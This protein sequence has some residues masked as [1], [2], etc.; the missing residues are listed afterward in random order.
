MPATAYLATFIVSAIAH[1]F[2]V[3][4]NGYSSSTVENGTT[5]PIPWA[6][7]YAIVSQ[8]AGFQPKTRQYR[9]IFYTEIDFNTME[10]L[11]GATGVVTTPRQASAN[12]KLTECS[13]DDMTDSSDPLG[14]LSA[15]LKFTLL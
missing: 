8:T 10:N 4:T 2:D 3:R 6:P 5:R 7:T 15:I 13:R 14:G 1:G 9:V 11:V 12:A